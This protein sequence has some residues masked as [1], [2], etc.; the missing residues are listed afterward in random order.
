MLQNDFVQCKKQAPRS[1]TSVAVAR[2]RPFMNH[3]L[4]SGEKWY[5]MKH[6]RES[7]MKYVFLF[8]AVMTVAAVIIIC[9]FLFCQ[10][11]PGHGGNRIL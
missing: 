5:N 1:R 3:R 7:F 6:F 11:Y 8:A 2:S 10:R 4:C 9:I